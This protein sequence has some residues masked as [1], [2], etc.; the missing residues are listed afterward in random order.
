MNYIF[1]LF[2]LIFCRIPSLI[3]L[4]QCGIEMFVRHASLVRPIGEEG[5]ARLSVDF[6]QVRL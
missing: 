1:N 5:K 2:L 3:I 4:A 6:A